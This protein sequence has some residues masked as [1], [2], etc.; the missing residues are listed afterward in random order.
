MAGR[1]QTLAVHVPLPVRIAARYRPFV[2]TVRLQFLDPAG[3]LLLAHHAERMEVHLYAA[4]HLHDAA[5]LH[6]FTDV[7]CPLC[8]AAPVLRAAHPD[9][10][11][12]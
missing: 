10:S 5:D 1:L 9:S 2:H 3:R 7:L 4:A 6:R 8:A 11:L 12:P